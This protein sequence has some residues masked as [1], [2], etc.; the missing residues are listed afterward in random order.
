MNNFEREFFKDPK[1]E[2]FDIGTQVFCDICNK[3]YSFLSDS[4][5]F[6]FGSKA[7]CPECAKE[8]LPSIK[9][10]NEESYI[11]AICPENM[12]FWCWVVGLRDGN[13]TIKIITEK[14]EN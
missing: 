4:G 8:A 7:Y 6:L 13:N 3:D 12:S 10:Y 9:K 2:T 1:T 14:D 11:K 5:G